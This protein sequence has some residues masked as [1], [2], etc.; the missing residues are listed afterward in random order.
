MV[1]EKCGKEIESPLELYDGKLACEHCKS[2]FEI[3]KLLID[4]ENQ[5]LFDLSE[6]I[7]HEALQ[8]VGKKQYGGIDRAVSM[9]RNAAYQG[10]PYAIIRLAYYYEM[11]YGKLSVNTAFK[12][13]CGYYETVWKNGFDD[14]SLKDYANLRLIAAKRHLAFL[15][16]I[17]QNLRHLEIY[18]ATNVRNRMR[19]YFVL[20]DDDAAGG[21]TTVT[22]LTAGARI[23]AVLESCLGT[24]R[25]PLFG[26]LAVRGE[27]FVAWAHGKMTGGR[28]DMAQLDYYLRTGNF[29][30]Y[31]QGLEKKV[32]FPIKQLKHVQRDFN[33]PKSPIKPDQTYYLLFFNEKV[34]RFGKAIRF[35]M[36]DGGRLDPRLGDV[37]N[38]ARNNGYVDYVFYPDDILKYKETFIES[39]KH[40]TGNLLTEVIRNADK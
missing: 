1:C 31:L 20:P 2:N 32:G 26:L 35:L 14:G 16:R 15:E 11:G 28:N 5:K 22:E 18:N 10:N 4:E 38:K 29:G 39:I 6:I 13:A 36:P 30:F 40:A 3:K 17:P 37:I 33:D 27:D 21:G 7:F 9:C 12:A 34:K 23:N 24:G 8:N 19:N 25:V